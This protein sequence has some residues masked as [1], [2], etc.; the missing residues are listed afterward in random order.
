MFYLSKI[1]SAI[2]QPMFWLAIWWFA[3][4]VIISKWRRAAHNHVVVRFVRFIFVGV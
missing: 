2:T 3:A 1:L 4:L